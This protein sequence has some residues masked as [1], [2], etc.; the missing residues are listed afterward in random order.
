MNDIFPEHFRSRKEIEKCVED[1]RN[2]N[3]NT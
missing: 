1:N 3:K 2:W